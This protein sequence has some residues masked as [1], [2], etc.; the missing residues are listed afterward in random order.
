M[1][2]SI[3]SNLLAVFKEDNMS[4]SPSP[5][6][7]PNECI[8]IWNTCVYLFVCSFIHSIIHII[9]N[10]YLQ[11]YNLNKNAEVNWRQH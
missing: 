1:T 9:G 5:A 7:I 8:A 4:L 3:H 10:T 2:T 6:V 11:E